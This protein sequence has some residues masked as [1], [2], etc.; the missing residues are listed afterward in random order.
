V[1]A[2]GE[3]SVGRESRAGDVWAAFSRVA[4]SGVDAVAR[5]AAMAAHRSGPSIEPADPRTPAAPLPA[6][7]LGGRRG[8]AGGFAD[9]YCGARLQSRLPERNLRK[10]FGCDRLSGRCSLPADRGQQSAPARCATLAHL[11]ST[12]NPDA[13]DGREHPARS[14]R[15]PGQ[16]TSGPG[17]KTR[18]CGGLTASMTSSTRRQRTSPLGRNGQPQPSRAVPPIG[19]RR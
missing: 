1:K 5:R 7:A 8:P 15:R 18:R 10:L 2:A 4:E 3:W 13:G 16:S 17:D 6:P 14:P 19:G 12:L 11:R 9:N